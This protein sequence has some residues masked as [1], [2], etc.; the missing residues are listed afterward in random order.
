[1]NYILTHKKESFMTAFKVV[2]ILGMLA[3]TLVPAAIGIGVVI[4]IS[5]YYNKK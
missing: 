5:S 3:G 1:M 2:S 4:N